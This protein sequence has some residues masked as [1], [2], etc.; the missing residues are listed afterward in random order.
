MLD[1]IQRM[2]LTLLIVPN[3]HGRGR[4]EHHSEFRFA[5]DK[6]LADGD[7][8][9]LHGYYHLDSS[10]PP[11][12]ARDWIERRVLTQSEGEFAALSCAGARARL[13]WG[14]TLM[15]SLGWP[16]KGFVAPAW[17]LG[18]E[19]RSALAEFSF[20]YTTTRTGFYR[21][22]DWSFTRSPTL[23]YSV[24]SPWRR[25]MSLVLNR[26][27]LAAFSQIPLLRLSLHPVDAM[28]TEVLAQ[29][30]DLIVRALQTHQ[31]VTKAHWASI[32]ADAPHHLS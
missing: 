29:W 3:Y 7:E 19:S 18:E 23:V 8:I 4:I 28:Y 24:R 14:M 31:P 17:L 6:R 5:L 20:E 16:V 11:R 2:P 1:S 12:T 15:R 26:T 22:P 13:D 9:A 21:L 10:P 32:A 30:R 25:A 27:Q